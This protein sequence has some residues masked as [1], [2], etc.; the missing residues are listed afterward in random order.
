M[1]QFQLNLGQ[2]ILRCRENQG[3]FFQ[4]KGHAVFSGEIIADIHG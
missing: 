3:V 1:G 4:M 2:S